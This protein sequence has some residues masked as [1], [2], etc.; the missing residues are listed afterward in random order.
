MLRK[1]ITGEANVSQHLCQLVLAVAQNEICAIN[2]DNVAVVFIA[3]F[4]GG[5]P[6]Y[7]CVC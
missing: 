3:T 7:L 5:F 1:I 6:Y 4:F 2:R